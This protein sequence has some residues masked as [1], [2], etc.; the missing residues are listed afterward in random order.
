[1]IEQYILLT[2]TAK[3]LKNILYLI[4]KKKIQKNIRGEEIL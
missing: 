3:S 4:E 1:M 2:H